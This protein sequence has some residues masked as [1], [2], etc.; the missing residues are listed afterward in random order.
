[1]TR[2]YILSAINICL[3][4][5]LF[6]ILLIGIINIHLLTKN[7]LLLFILGIIIYSILIISLYLSKN[8]KKYNIGVMLT[9]IINILV[10]FEISTLN[11]E[12]SYINNLINKE[13]NYRNYS[14]YVQKVNTKY[15]NLKKLEGKTIGL[16]INNRENVVSSLDSK[17][18]IKYKTYRDLN[19]LFEA[20]KN[21]EIQ[22]FII[23]EKQNNEFKEN[24]N[25]NKVRKIY[26]NIIKESV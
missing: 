1:M 14:I 7:E 4:L 22:A 2:K 19:E 17:I 8:N 13:Y 21:G 26:S 25:K 23:S 16:L 10:A 24:E 20:I 5:S 12:Y 9:I 15:S 11:K 3:M 6:I 18:K